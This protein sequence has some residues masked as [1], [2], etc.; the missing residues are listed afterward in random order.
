M[1]LLVLSREFPPG[2][3]GIGTHAYELSRHLMRRGWE[4]TV[5]SPQDYASAAERER[6]NAAQ[7]FP[8]VRLNSGRGMLREAWERQGVLARQV[9][10]RRPDILLASGQRS[11]WLAAWGAA[12]HR[13]P[14]V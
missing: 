9:R 14:W 11:V 4:V 2:P 12:R 13:L 10:E 5:V 7:P 8:I 3:G 1:R 6:F